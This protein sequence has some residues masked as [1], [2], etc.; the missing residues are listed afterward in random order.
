[1]SRS[2]IRISFKD[3]YQ[4]RGSIHNNSSHVFQPFQ[5]TLKYDQDLG[6]PTILI[7]ALNEMAKLI[8]L[9]SLAISMII[10][11]RQYGWFL[12]LSK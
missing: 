12:R 11:L 9:T 7:S 10:I 5:V 2:V 4:P 8:D 6:F 3:A 1:M